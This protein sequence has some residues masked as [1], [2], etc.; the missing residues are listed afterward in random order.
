MNVVSMESS[1]LF[2]LGRNRNRNSHRPTHPFRPFAP[3]Q[4]FGVFY[5]HVPIRMTVIKMESGGLFVY[6]P[7]APTTECLELLQ[8]LIDEH[9]PIRYIVLPS[10]APEHKV[11]P[12]PPYLCRCTSLSISISMSMSIY[13]YLSIYLSISL[14]IY[15]FMYLSIYPSIYIYLSIYLSLISISIYIY[16]IPP[17]H[18]DA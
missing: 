11:P 15:L 12:I 1:G 7:V 9:G 18:V 17:A 5:V 6:A 10:V 3:I 13:P 14:S 2:G 8:P 16:I 4:I